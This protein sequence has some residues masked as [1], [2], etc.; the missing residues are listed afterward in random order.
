MLAIFICI[1]V[2]TLLLGR[3]LSVHK[4]KVKPPIELVHLFIFILWH[5]H[6]L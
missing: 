6:S 1:A 2:Q 3:K 4:L 5:V